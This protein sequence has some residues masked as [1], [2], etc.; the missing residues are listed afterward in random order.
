M[1]RTAKAKKTETSPKLDPD[2]QKG[3][4]TLGSLRWLPGLCP[5]MPHPAQAD[6]LSLVCREAM[7]GGAAG[8]GKSD[9]LLMAAL[10]YVDVPGYAALILRKSFA[11]LAL[12]DAIM[13]R[14]MAWLRG[15]EGI[16]WDD[17]RK[18]FTFPSGATLTFGYLKYEADR[19]RYQGSAYQFIGFDELTQFREDEYTYLLSRLRKPKDGPLSQVPLR[20]RG[21]TN[22]GGVGHEWVKARFIPQ[23][24]VLTG[25]LRPAMDENGEPR[26]FIP[27]KLDDN[28]SLDRDSYLRNLNLL[29]PVVRAQLRDGDWGARPPGEMFDRQYFRIVQSVSELPIVRWVRTWDLASTE[30]RRPGHDPDYTVGM[31][32]GVTDDHRILIA[33]IRRFQKRPGDTR[34][35]MAAIAEADYKVFGHRTIRVEQ[36]PGSSG[37]YAIE[38][39]ATDLRAYD[40]EGVR[41]TGP[42]TERAAPVSAAASNG[43]L[44]VLAAPWLPDFLTEVEAFPQESMHDDQ[45]DAMSLGYWCLVTGYAA[46]GGAVP[47]V[48]QGKRSPYSARRQDVLAGGRRRRAS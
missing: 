27:A 21:A 6:F 30:K 19:Y 28:P 2:T 40:I 47:N 18:T 4:D 25:T 8:G 15:R 13:S 35:L 9:A 1:A 36:E 22:P 29:P 14:A 3:L 12:P 16:R 42:K 33:D 39:I 48:L 34:R 46:A 5:H 38:Q 37:E 11:D 17:V 23:E 7:Y 43:R 44:Y 32:L 45:V 31:L 20:I 24:D 26:T 41:S 10:Q